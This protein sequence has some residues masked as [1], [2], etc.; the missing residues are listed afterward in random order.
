MDFLYVSESKFISIDTLICPTVCV[1][2]G[3]VKCRK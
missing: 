3:Q 1:G 2:G